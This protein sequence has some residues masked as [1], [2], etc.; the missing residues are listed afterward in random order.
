MNFISAADILGDD[1]WSRSATLQGHPALPSGRYEFIDLYCTD[2]SCD[3]RKTIFHIHHEG[4][5]VS[6]VNF[7]WEDEIF[8]LKWMGAGSD[9]EMA[10]DMS[11]WS[12]DFM[13]PDR[14]PPEEIIEWMESLMD[15]HWLA[16][17]KK[18]YRMVRKAQDTNIIRFEP[19]ISRN[20]PCPCG[21]GRKYK[22]CCLNK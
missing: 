19:K 17:I 7:G 22:Q 20:A 4:Q 14:L 2:T 11:G 21:S 1:Y 3:C 18:H 9:D 12:S 10:K 6:T 8:Y 15:D 5:H 13:S 16:K